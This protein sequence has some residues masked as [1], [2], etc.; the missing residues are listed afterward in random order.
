MFN[1]NDADYINPFTRPNLYPVTQKHTSANP[2]PNPS[3]IQRCSIAVAGSRARS[4]IKP[5]TS[6]RP[7]LAQPGWLN[8]PSIS[9]MKPPA[10][11]LSHPLSRLLS[12]EGP[13][14]NLL[15][16]LS[17]TQFGQRSLVH[18]PAIESLR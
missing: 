3:P 4:L 7:P 10:P 18:D 17:K 8:I 1:L 9:C 6:D 13:S 15:Q 14:L 11:L 12:A 2:Q 5:Q 16:S